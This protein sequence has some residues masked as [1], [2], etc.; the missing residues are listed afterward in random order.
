MKPRG[1]DLP[2]ILAATIGRG[3]HWAGNAFM[4]GTARIF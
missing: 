1:A 4:P 3:K 2:S